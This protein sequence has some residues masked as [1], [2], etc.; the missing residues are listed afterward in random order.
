MGVVV[1]QLNGSGAEPGDAAVDGLSGDA[2]AV[3]ES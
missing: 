1:G 3:P 2:G